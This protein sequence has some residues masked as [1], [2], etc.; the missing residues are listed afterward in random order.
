MLCKNSETPVDKLEMAVTFII[1]FMLFS[2]FTDRY[3]IEPCG[4]PVLARRPYVWHSCYKGFIN[5]WLQGSKTEKTEA[6]SA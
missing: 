5:G 6:S 2:H 4:G 1:T 3:Q